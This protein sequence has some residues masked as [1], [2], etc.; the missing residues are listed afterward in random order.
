MKEGMP[1]VL[2]ASQPFAMLAQSESR[3][4]GAAA[5]PRVVIAHPGETDSDEDVEAMARDA[6]AGVL[7]A[8]G[9][10]ATP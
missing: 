1:V 7:D 5:L 4:R 10:G 8:F 6:L 3:A 9:W 2:L